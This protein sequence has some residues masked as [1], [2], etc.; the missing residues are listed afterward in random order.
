MHSVYNKLRMIP[1]L[2][3]CRMTKQRELILSIV[4][5]SEAHLSAEEVYLAAREQMPTI[6]LATVY[7]SLKYLSEGGYIVRLTFADQ[8][9]RYDKMFV[10]HEH[11][12]CST[13]GKIRDIR[14]EGIDAFLQ[15]HAD[16]DI[17]SYDLTLHYQCSTCRQAAKHN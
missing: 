14:I 17:T 2:K 6:A 8:P 9:D 15:D 5:G 13:C 16:K 11:M 1:I 12:V 3:E 7:N 10:P 4:R